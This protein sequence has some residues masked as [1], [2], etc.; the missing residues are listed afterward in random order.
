ME[1]IHPEILSS[2]DN[3]LKKSGNGRSLCIPNIGN[4][5]G[6]FWIFKLNIRSLVNSRFRSGCSLRNSD[7]RGRL[8]CR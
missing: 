8:K 3:I 6:I 7:Q 1:N 2:F 4:G 5:S